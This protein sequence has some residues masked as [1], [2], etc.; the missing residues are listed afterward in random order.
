[1][2]IVGTV[3]LA[4]PADNLQSQLTRLFGPIQVGASQLSVS[5]M[6]TI[7][8]PAF[9]LTNVTTSLDFV[10]QFI[11]DDDPSAL[12]DFCKEAMTRDKVGWQLSGV[13]TTHVGWLP[14]NNH[15]VLD[16]WVTMDGMAG[17]KHTEMKNMVFP[18]PHPLGG[19]AIQGMV[20]IYN[21]SRTLS[22]TLGNVDFGIYLIDDENEQDVMIGVVRALETQ[23]LGQRMNYFTVSGRTLP[24]D[25]NTDTRKQQLLE[26]F[27]TQ[28]LHGNTSMVRV[29]GNAFGPD[30]DQ[31]HFSIPDWLQRTLASIT[32]TFPFPGT[33]QHDNMIQSL[34]MHHLN[35]DLSSTLPLVSGDTV[36]F[37]HLPKEMKGVAVDVTEIQP[38]V[39]LY[40]DPDST[41]PFARLHPPHPCSSNTTT[42]RVA[43]RIDKAPLDILHQ[44]TFDAFLESVYQDN[45]VTLYLQGTTR[46][47]VISEFGTLYV[48]DL[49]L[50]GQIKATGMQ[51]MKH[52][53]PQV[54]SLAI[55]QGFPDALQVQ[56]RLVIANPSNMDLNLGSIT[57]AMLYKDI[58]IGNV[59][60]QQLKLIHESSNAFDSQ[61]HIFATPIPLRGTCGNTQAPSPMV[62]FIGDYISGLQT[63]LVIAGR[64]AGSN[65]LNGLLRLLVFSIHIPRFDKPPL[66]Q[67]IQMNLLSS[68]ALVWLR[69]PFQGIDMRI[70]TMNASAVYQDQLVGTMVAD[71]IVTLP[72]VK[73]SN[74]NDC[75][76]AVV[77]TPKIPVVLKKFG[78]DVIS[79][80]LGGTL[81]LTIDSIVNVMID[82]FKLT[83]LHYKRDNI[84]AI[85][86]KSF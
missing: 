40:L 46:A 16:K 24:L 73:C 44:T 39:Y 25:D 86:K 12:I 22:M 19:I 35:I 43:S 17:L 58:E 48:D 11:V 56:P 2:H 14:F 61:G 82:S 30:D 52:P 67:G 4:S 51:G 66:L 6:G 60:I 29:R 1:M 53:A 13:M 31:V 38:D 84:T 72:P 50:D 21:P 54:T 32:L 59:T 8:L 34:T 23:L 63:E 69:N 70:S 41:E 80:A 45:N 71:F 76:G 26:Q 64:Q 27:L 7:Q 5:S 65:Y 18:G 77:V 10:T 79:K 33:T 68:T 36:A 20:G 55:I 78:L 83:N 57:F 85:I 81:I 28:Y 74:D 49:K 37:L 9:M 15:I 3:T 75:T 47:L 62:H 42:T